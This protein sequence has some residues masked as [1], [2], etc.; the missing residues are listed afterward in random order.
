MKRWMTLVWLLAAV[1]FAFSLFGD[2]RAQPPLAE[3]ARLSSPPLI[4][5]DGV[6][7]ACP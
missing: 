3:R 1:V 5:Y 7:T 4:A 2:A 6:H